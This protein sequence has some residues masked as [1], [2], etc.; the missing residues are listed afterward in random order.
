M[1]TG[2]RVAYHGIRA[3]PVRSHAATDG[4]GTRTRPLGAESLPIDRLL[5]ALSP[6][7]WTGP[8]RRRIMLPVPK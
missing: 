3:R 8:R 2:E 6:L 7:R 4:P 5:C 1:P